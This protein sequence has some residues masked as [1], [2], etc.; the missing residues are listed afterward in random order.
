MTAISKAAPRRWRIGPSAPSRVWNRIG[1]DIQDQIVEMALEETDL[2]PR[3]L[4]VRFTD[5][6]LN[7]NSPSFAPDGKTVYFLSAQ[8]G[9][10]QL[11]A[12]P[13]GGTQAV[14][15]SDYPLDIGSYKLSPDGRQIALSFEVFPDCRDLDCTKQR[16]DAKAADKSSGMLFDQLFVRH[17]DTWKDGRQSTLFA[18]DLPAAGGE[19]SSRTWS[20]PI[21]SRRRWDKSVRSSGESSSPAR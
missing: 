11:W 14:Q 6:A 18:A 20:A 5:E 1:D 15:I 17:W 3:E 21:I 19:P 2:S 8:S 9:S 16:L 4:A 13:V 7:V 12:Q 10:M